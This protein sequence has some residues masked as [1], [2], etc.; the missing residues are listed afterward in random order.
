M[1]GRGYIDNGATTP[2]G[3]LVISFGVEVDYCCLSMSQNEL[4][5]CLVW[6]MVQK[7]GQVTMSKDQSD[8]PR[9]GQESSA[10]FQKIN[11]HWVCLLSS[12]CLGKSTNAAP[13][14]VLYPSAIIMPWI[15]CTK[16]TRHTS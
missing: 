8:N 10:L 1:S 13:R 12:W 11:L 4:M 6:D 5:T 15:L 3:V 2:V 16:K 9:T 7:L 14:L